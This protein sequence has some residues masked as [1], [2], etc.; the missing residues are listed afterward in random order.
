[1]RAKDGRS[2]GGI[3]ISEAF[4][5]PQTYAGFSDVVVDITALPAEL[6]FPLIAT[7]LDIWHSETPRPQSLGNLHITVCH[8]PEVD[9][10]ILPEGGDKADLM[11]G[12]PG[13]LQRASI[14][15]PIGVWAPVLGENQFGRLQK[16]T[17]FVGPEVVAP[18]LPFPAKNPRRGDELILEYRSLIFDTWAVDPTDFIYAD[19]HNPF[20]L[21]S[22]LCALS[23][24]YKESLRSIGTAQMV[25][26]SHSSKLHALGV[27][28]ASW[29][30]G[31]G[32]S[33]VQPTGHTVNGSFGLE[34]ENG[35]LFEIW[36]AG[37]AY[38]GA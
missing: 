35:E 23:S 36:L 11:Y 31:F 8:N 19:E 2:I 13:T 26:S 34:H 15:N 16:I 25:V 29:E 33:H 32:V 18:V 37:D 30:Q 28:L 9:S 21:Y 24:N 7:L 14:G 38:D 1:M 20:D 6:Y 22:K 17:E 3:R 4:R 10:M 5:D 12:F 27:L